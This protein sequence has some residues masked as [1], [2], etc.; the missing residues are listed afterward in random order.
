MTLHVSFTEKRLS[1]FMFILN[2]MSVLKAWMIS[3]VE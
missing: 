2:T 3:D 1:F